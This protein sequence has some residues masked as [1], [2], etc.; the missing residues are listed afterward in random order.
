[1][2]D[3]IN[4][5]TTAVTPAVLWGTLADAAPIIT[6]MLVFAFG[7]FVLKRVIRGIGHGKARL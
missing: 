1:M 5:L 2:S 7:Y 6:V 3:F 4:A